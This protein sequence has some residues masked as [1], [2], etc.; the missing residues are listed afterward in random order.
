MPFLSSRNSST[1]TTITTS[2]NRSSMELPPSSLSSGAHGSSSMGLRRQN[3]V[4]A[5]S[6]AASSSHQPA[7]PSSSD[8][9]TP[10]VWQRTIKALTCC[11]PRTD[12]FAK[13]VL[14]S[15]YWH[16]LSVA[17][18]LII[19]FGP[20][21]QHLIVPKNGDIVCDIIYTITVLFFYIDIFLRSRADT[22]YLKFY[23]CGKGCGGEQQGTCIVGSFLFWCDLV[24]TS[25]MLYDI[26]YINQ[27]H[28]EILTREIILASSGKPVRHAHI[29]GSSRTSDEDSIFI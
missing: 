21:I 18:T 4:S 27:A 28:F 14:L 12:H 11:G 19:L 22:D 3:D 10:N 13:Q 8:H 26:S 23:I 20:P 17:F 5:D 2:H 24:S 1:E 16:S 9:P 29:L 6:L 25:I 15:R 7:T